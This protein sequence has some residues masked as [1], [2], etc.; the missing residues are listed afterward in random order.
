MVSFCEDTEGEQ[1]W[2]LLHDVMTLPNGRIFLDLLGFFASRGQKF[3]GLI[4]PENVVDLPGW[5]KISEKVQHY[6][7]GIFDLT[8]FKISHCQVCICIL[9]IPQ[10]EA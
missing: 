5:S 10:E 4:F 1:Q 2:W 9:K 7:V 3:S 6:Q 8:I